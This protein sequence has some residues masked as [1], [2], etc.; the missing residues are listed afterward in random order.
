MSSS[1]LGAIRADLET[2][3]TEMERVRRI[4]IGADGSNGLKAEVAR[5][6]ESWE[7]S[8][9]SKRDLYLLIGAVGAACGALGF[10]ISHILNTGAP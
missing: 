6:R 8:K 2:L 3:K 7:A 4:L 9:Q 5:L 1:D 10:F